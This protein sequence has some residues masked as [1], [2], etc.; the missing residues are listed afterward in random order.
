M[1]FKIEDNGL[2]L[3][4][5]DK[6][7][8]LSAVILHSHLGKKVKVAEAKY[9]TDLGKY[10]MIPLVNE[11]YFLDEYDWLVYDSFKY[12]MSLGNKLL[13]DRASYY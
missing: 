4:S 2:T 10:V 11:T 9:H 5:T 1:N 6:V 12:L 13:N 8:L 3:I 7:E